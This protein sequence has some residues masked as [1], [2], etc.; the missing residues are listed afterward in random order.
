MAEQIELSDLDRAE[1]RIKYYQNRERIIMERHKAAFKY[2]NGLYQKVLKKIKRIKEERDE[3]RVLFVR[4]RN[5][6][7]GF[8]IEHHTKEFGWEY[9][10]K[11]DDI[12]E[13]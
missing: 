8:G 4:Q 5:C 2:F 3:M 12:L 1:L 7:S 9:L 13:E 6:E 10:L 11:R